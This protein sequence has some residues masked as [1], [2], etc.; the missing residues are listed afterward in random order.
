MNFREFDQKRLELL[1]NK[2]MRIRALKDE[3]ES[4][5]SRLSEAESKRLLLEH[6]ERME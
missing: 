3:I 6:E 4:E 2:D 5:L 1:E